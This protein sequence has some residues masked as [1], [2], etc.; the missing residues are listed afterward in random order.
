MGFV[1]YTMSPI[2]KTFVKS[3]AD[4]FVIPRPK[5]GITYRAARRLVYYLTLV[6]GIF[7][8][9]H[10]TLFPLYQFVYGTY[11]HR[12]ALAEM[13]FDIILVED[14]PL[15]PFCL[16]IKQDKTRV[17]FDAREYYPAEFENSLVFRIFRAPERLHM[18]KT[19]LPHLDAFYTVSEGLADLYDKEFGIRPSV[20]RSTPTFVAI[21]PRP[22]TNYP[23]KMVYHG[24][25]NFDRRLEDMIDVM[26]RLD[27]RYQLDLYLVESKAFERHIS[28]LKRKASGC[29]RVRFMPPVPFSEINNMLRSYDVGFVLY[30]Q[31]T[32]N[33]RHCLPNKFFEF[34]QARLA[35]AIGPSP[36]MAP[37][38]R[39]YEIGLIADD[40]SVDAMV[41]VLL[42]ADL[43]LI[44]KL[45]INTDR[46]AHELCWESESRKLRDIVLYTKKE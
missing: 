20:V 46:A 9:P 44:N 42:K 13:A 32:I 41:D 10:S 17:I 37:I 43:E 21:K 25:A 38:A 6:G 29:S 22:A 11:V 1:V 26:L 36:E 28:K 14:L 12:K 15:V 2:P 31:Q 33:L 7:K 27:N 23:I 39:K 3:I 8:V 18:C 24:G 16:A 4:T 45:K 40:F 5:K 19:C 30:N 35:V 34:I